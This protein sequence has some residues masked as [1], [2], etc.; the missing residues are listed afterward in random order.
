MRVLNWVLQSRFKSRPKI[1]SNPV[2]PRVSFG[3]PPPKHIFNPGSL[4]FSRW[5]HSCSQSPDPRL[6]WPALRELLRM[7][8]HCFKHLG[9][10][11]QSQLVIDVNH[12]KMTSLPYGV[13]K[14]ETEIWL[15][16]FSRSS[17]VPFDTFDWRVSKPVN[18]P[19]CQLAYYTVVYQKQDLHCVIMRGEESKVSGNRREA[20]GREEVR[21]LSPLTRV[22]PLNGDLAPRLTVVSSTTL[23]NSTHAL[24]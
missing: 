10:F 11:S 13:V 2:I 24:L 3:I 1:W 21:N 23:L 14:S 17:C 12:V 9:T 6:F 7:R 4:P 5:N 20:R 16:F 18:S 8:K 19:G 22:W 15:C